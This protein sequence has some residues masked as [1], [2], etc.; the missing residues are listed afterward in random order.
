[1]SKF[2]EDFIKLHNKLS[3]TSN[4][5]PRIP[6]PMQGAIVSCATHE[7][8]YQAG[9]FY[10]C[11]GVP[12]SL[13]DDHIT[14]SLQSGRQY[15]GVI[16]GNF[17]IYNGDEVTSNQDGYNLYSLSDINYRD[18][19]RAYSSPNDAIICETPESAVYL[20]MLADEQ[21]Y[22]WSS[23]SRYSDTNMFYERNDF[24]R[25]YN[26]HE[27]L[28]SEDGAGWSSRIRLQKLLFGTNNSV[29][30]LPEGL[31]FDELRLNSINIVFRQMPGSYSDDL[32]RII[33][34]KVSNDINDLLLYVNHEGCVKNRRGL[35]STDRAIILE[36][37]DEEKRTWRD[38]HRQYQVLLAKER[39]YARRLLMLRRKEYL[40]SYEMRQ[41]QQMYPVTENQLFSYRM[42]QFLF[43][44]WETNKIAKTLLKLNNLGYTK[45]SLR[46]ITISKSTQEM[47]YTLPNKDTVMTENDRWEKRGRQSGK[48]G[49]ILR[50]VLVE[51]VPKFKINDSELEQLVNHLKA[52]ADNGEF[53]IVSGEDIQYWYD[54]NVYADDEDTGTLGSSCMRHHTHYMELY[55]KNPDV[56]QMVILVKDNVLYGRALLW[57]GKWMDRIYGSDSTITAF[58]AYAKKKGFHSK[59]GQNS[60]NYDRWINPE[61]GE[62]YYQTITISLDTDCDYYPYADTFF[63]IDLD[64][65]MISNGEISSGATLRSTD[66]DIYDDDRVYDEYND[67]YIDEGDAV[68]MDYRGYSTHIDDARYCE[69]T[70]QYYLED[71]MVILSN[72][73]LVYEDAP[74]IVYCDQDEVYAHIEDTFTC[75][76]DDNI[77]CANNN[78]SEYIDELGITV[79]ELNVEDAYLDAGYV[80]NDETMEW[81][82]SKTKQ[83]A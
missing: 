23:G 14:Q 78:T 2:K 7:E 33:F 56:C 34:K 6:L 37:T 58:K 71:D 24:S 38:A 12:A 77:Y 11:M 79:H 39:V 16:G 1:M 62:E 42:H 28:H 20:G 75:E 46:N 66:G 22:R 59:S 45:G 10:L 65:G 40:K 9:I 15:V 81:E 73:D 60:D 76:H 67:R 26:L 29:I 35:L 70:C 44:V 82:E 25:C 8:V 48:Y 51:Q 36:A 18:E 74:D 52:C 47:T 30:L 55:A 83:E 32:H 49:K 80:Y 50:K 17:G 3:W 31:N 63:F 21:G 43:K 27:G 64:E 54:G 57:E 53:Q 41:L 13:D 19:I 72:G 4:R 61:T 68:Y 5:T 69:I